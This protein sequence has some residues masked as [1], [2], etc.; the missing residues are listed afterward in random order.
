MSGYYVPVGI[1][2][3]EPEMF[4]DVALYIRSGN[5]FVL[6]KSHG[7]NFSKQ[8]A[9]RLAGNSIDFLYVSPADMEVITKYLEDNAERILKSDKFDG[10]TKG[11]IIYQ[12]SINFV[13]DIFQNPKKVGDFDRSK[14]LMENLLMYLSSDSDALSSLETVMTHNYHT[15]VH[16]LQVTALSAL[17]HSEAFSLAHDE[18]VDVGIGSLLHDFGKTFISQK[19]LNKT[20]KLTPEDIATIKRHP[21]EGY[22][23]LKENTH[24]NEIPLS[25]VRDHHERVNGKGYPR[26]LKREDI[27]RSAQV[28]GLCDVYCT[29]TI[30][31]NGGKAL[32]SYITI[33]I[34][35]QE[36]QDAFDKRLLDI[37]EGITCTE[38]VQQHVL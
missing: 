2:S 38:E 14:R 35:R 12:T 1:E 4:P 37:L 19:V 34:M 16:S 5:N 11:K 21:E 20:G 32:P 25:I 15:F 6:Y 23:Y 13:G 31:R 26:G 36:M 3:I 22:K 17:V 30:D 27:G 28:G 7:H 8:D 18:M 10:K 9:V 33:Q 24:L 29:L